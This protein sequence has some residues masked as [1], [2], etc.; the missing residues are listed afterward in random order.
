MPEL[1]HDVARVRAL[2][3]DLGLDSMVDI[4][5][6]FMPHNVLAKVWGYFDAV[7]PRLG[8]PWPIE[9]RTAEDER[10]HRLRAYG[11]ERFTSLL[12]PH[13]P[14]MAQWLNGW[15]AEFDARTPDCVRTGTFYPEAEAASY[16]RAAIDDGVG[17]FKCHVQVGDYDVHDPLLDDVW[18]AIQNADVPVVIHCGSGPEPGRFT[19][20]DPVEALMRRFPRLP[21]VIAHMGMPEYGRFLDLA[22]RY[23]SVRLDTTMVFT[24]F[25]ERLAPFPVDLRP[26]L[27][28]LQKRIL[29]GSDFPNIPYPYADALRAV[30]ELGLGDDWA[31]DVVRE[32]GRGLVG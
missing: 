15:A 30:M 17:V 31:R 4:H 24:A 7:E 26:R 23:E 32:N 5:T 6:H 14:G 3:A 21:L 28:D 8:Q 29:F 16:V 27:L 11:V 10:T 2:L 13:R 12:Y 25:S 18:G 9:Y 20:P 22:D 1:D 19:G